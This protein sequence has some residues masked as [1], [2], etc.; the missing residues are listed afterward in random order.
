MPNPKISFLSADFVEMIIAEA[1]DVLIN[2]GVK[3]QNLAILSLLPDY[4]AQVDHD[5]KIAKIPKTIIQKALDTTPSEFYLRITT[6]VEN[7]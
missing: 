2:P 3:V 5:L 7:K 4:G 1:M 6:G